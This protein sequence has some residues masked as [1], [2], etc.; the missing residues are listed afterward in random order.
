MQLKSS[1]VFSLCTCPP[2]WLSSLCLLADCL[3]ACLPTEPAFSSSGARTAIEAVC[4]ISP[5][6]T[7]HLLLHHQLASSSATA[8]PLSATA[9]MRAATVGAGCQRSRPPHRFRHTHPPL[10][11]RT[12]RPAHVRTHTHMATVR[13]CGSQ[14][15]RLGTNRGNG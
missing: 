3:P 14:A 15:D 10:H 5:L 6:S 12:Q 1:F 8:A 7:L 11:P 4:C 2:A 13:T 9:A